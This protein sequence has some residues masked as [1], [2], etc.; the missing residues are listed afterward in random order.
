VRRATTDLE[1]HPAVADDGKSYWKS[2]EERDGD[3]RFLNVAADEF[4]AAIDPGPDQPSRRDF[5]AAAGFAFAGLTLAGCTRAPQRI[6]LPLVTQPMEVAPGRALHYASTCQA[7]SAGC[8]LLVKCRDGRPI[9][10][11]GNPEHSLSGGGLCAVG[12]ASILGLY[13]R[14]R[15]NQPL[16]NGQPS[17]WQ[18]VDSDI[19]SRLDDIRRQGGVVRLLSGSVLSPTLRRL[20]GT[21]LSRFPGARHVV[22][23]PLSCSAILDAH[24]RTH[25]IRALPHYRLDRAEVIVSFDADFL[26]TWVSPVE[27]SRAYRDGRSLAGNPPRCSWH[28]QLE[29]RLSL[30]GARADLRIRIAP[31]DQGPLL[32]HLA[33]RLARRANIAWSG[34]SLAPGSIPAPQLEELAERLWGA[35][36]RCVVL[37]GSDRPPEQVLCNFLNHLLG[38]YGTTLD[39][40]RPSLQKQGNKADVVR[41]LQELKDGRISALFV[42]DSNPVYNRCDGPEW[43]DALRRVPL[44]VVCAER[45]DETAA[46]AGYVC[47]HPHGL[48]SWSDAEPVRGLFS[49]SQPTFPPLGNTRTVLES[50]AAWSG[51]ARSARQLIQD[52]WRTHV[53]PRCRKGDR[54]LEESE[55]VPFSQD[56]QTFWDHAVHDGC[57]EAP[58]SAGEPP[59]FNPGVV[60]P[61]TGVERS[62]QGMLALVLYPK[63]GLLD[64]SHAYNPWLQEL[65]DPITKVAW[66]NYACVSP[67]T[68]RSMRLADGDVLRVEANGTSLELPA[69]IQPGQHDGVVAIPLGYGSKLSERFAEVGPRWL[70]A[71]PTLGPDGRVGVNAA[72]LLS[73]RAVRLT[74]TG[75]S[76]PLAA[77]QTHH[78]ITV[79]ERLA[80]EGQRRRPMIQATT[81]GAL[82]RP[83]PPL[84]AEPAAELWPDDHA[85][86]G[87][88]WGMLI[89]LAACT[90]CSACVVACQVENNI[91]VVGKDEVRR[92]REMHWLRIDRYYSDDGPGEVDVAFQP[93]LCQHCGNA[94][95]ETVCPVLATVHSSEGLNQQVYNRCV[96]TRYC[97]N[98][99]PYKVRRFNWFAYS[100]EDALQNLVLNPDVVVRSRGV[101]EK[102]SFCVQRIQEAK[103]E[104]RRLG[105]PLADGEIKPACQQ[106][107]P[108][109]AI[110]FGDLND[111]GS[112][113]SRLLHERRRYQVLAEL[114]V[115]PAVHYLAVVRNRPEGEGEGHG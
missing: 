79:P 35:Q 40:E 106:S 59:W 95:C 104:A 66:D 43:T 71:Q 46:L 13:D 83:A 29:S 77:T 76:H 14:Q 42:V 5:L 26:G 105:R 111:G 107:C 82:S 24:E 15:I 70:E 112:A 90:G 23:D 27:F 1:E 103:L 57:V 74:K 64:G 41:L 110:H 94:P 38:N 58:P 39:L 113:V 56:F 31:D 45:L 96:G 101:M 9:K 55:P 2:P 69:L 78:T 102:C 32:T 3:P 75:R 100:R 92:Q 30:T 97:A 16:Q 65:P 28:A 68:A 53:F 54:H 93:M 44:L 80:P 89:D 60:R 84:H 19:R 48:A 49:L 52:E 86:T 114:N 6:A 20:V 87:H 61:V 62:A 36:G 81:V 12:Q 85:T 18:Q 7:C 33:D 50:L 10:L 22:H 63:V 73:K 88:R 11:E 72:P 109:G 98:N 67:A 115:R 37:C 25:G 108:A 21:F 4:P 91:P 34:P 8:G 17:T 99:C 47:P 51:N